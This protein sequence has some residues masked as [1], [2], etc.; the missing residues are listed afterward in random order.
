MH[1]ECA[2]TSLVSL[3]AKQPLV[4]AVDDNQDNLTILVHAIQLFGCSHISTLKGQAVMHLAKL[5]QPALILLDVVLPDLSG[6]EVLQLLKQTP[7]TT[8]IPV[9]AVTA[10]NQSKAR[11]PL[12][13]L[14]CADCLYKPYSL[15]DLEALL[16]RHLGSLQR[17][18][19]AS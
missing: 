2:D 5:Y 13:Q 6:L 10:L 17:Q 9:V 7:E 16:H 1:L 8:N 14:G 12:F 18:L 15:D 4:L 11:D 3:P 19:A